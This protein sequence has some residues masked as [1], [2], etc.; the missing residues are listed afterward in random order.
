MLSILFT[1][2][3]ID[4]NAKT[5]YKKHVSTFFLKLVYMYVQAQGECCFSWVNTTLLEAWIIRSIA[6]QHDSSDLCHFVHTVTSTDILNDK[7]R[8]KIQVKGHLEKIFSSF[9]SSVIMSA[10]SSIFTHFVHLLQNLFA[11]TLFNLH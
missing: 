2:L 8:E 6:G 9:C 4:K 10:Y 3:Y 5:Y 1:F 7:K 11:A